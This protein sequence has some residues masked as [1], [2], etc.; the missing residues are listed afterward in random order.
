MKL[1]ILALVDIR[2]GAGAQ[3]MRYFAGPFGVDTPFVAL[4]LVVGYR[5]CS[6]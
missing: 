4:D 6:G 3:Y 1:A 5:V 2:V